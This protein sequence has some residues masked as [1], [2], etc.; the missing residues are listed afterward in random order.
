MERR[1]GGN[2]L[3]EGVGGNGLGNREHRGAVEGGTESVERGIG[4]VEE[5][6]GGA[7]ELVLAADQAAGLALDQAEGGTR[8]GRWSD[9][10]EAV[11]VME[12]LN[13]KGDQ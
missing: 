7:D 5:M 8:R 1:V 2:R 4:P 13:K 12:N 9:A 6:E 3:G 10:R 11:L